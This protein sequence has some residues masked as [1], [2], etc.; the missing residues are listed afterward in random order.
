MT[1]R[2]LPWLVLALLSLAGA[3]QAAT[4][5]I[6][7]GDDPNA[8]LELRRTLLPSGVEVELVVLTG[9]RITLTIDDV[10]I[11]GQRIELDVEGRIVRVIGPGSFASGSERL[12]GSDMELRIDDEQV[13]AIDAVVFTSAIDV[14]GDVAERVPGQVSFSGGL[15]SPCTR[16]DQEVLD[17]AFRA[18]R[19][20]LYPGD[21]LV[22][23][24]V[25]LLLR[26]VAVLRLPLL[27]IPL[28]Q[29]DRQPRLA[30]ATGSAVR[31]AEVSLRWPY[32]AGRDALG[33][34]TVRY[35]ADV[36]P[37]TDAGL[38]G[39]LLG[40]TVEVS[41]LGF[42][43]DHRVYDEVGAGGLFVAYEPHRVGRAA[44]PGV[45]ARAPIDARWTVRLGYATAEDGAGTAVRA[46]LVRDDA[47]TAGR[48]IYLFG[49]AATDPTSLGDVGVR[50]QVD[51]QGF[52]DTDA[53]V[54]PRTPPAYADRRTPVR[55]PLRLRFE[56]L[57]VAPLQLGQLRVTALAL[58]LGLFQD[59]ANPINRRAAAAGLVAAGRALVGHGLV[60]DPWSP[61]A[62]V[63]IEGDNRFEGRYYG[64]DERAV[65]WRTRFGVTQNLGTWATVV[66]TL[67]RD[68]VEGETPFRF[69]AVAVR[70]RTDLQFRV[71][72]RPAPWVGLESSGGYVLVDNR[73]P[74]TVGWAPLTTRLTLFGDRP[75]IDASLEHVW[76]IRDDDP[77]T[78][79]S[80]LTLQARRTPV[81]LLVTLEHLQDLRPDPATPLVA[82]TVTRLT[83]RAAYE[84]VASLDVVAAYRPAPAPDAAGR[85]RRFEPIDVRLALGSLRGGDERPGVRLQAL[86]DPE[87]NRVERLTVD[88]RARAGAVEVEATQ[89]IEL[90]EGRVSDASL[91]VAWD[92]VAR[93]EARGLVWLPPA[94]LG[95]PEEPR[96]RQLSVQLR[97]Q[98][99]LGAPRWEA[100]WRSTVDPTLEAPGRRDTRFE[101]RAALLQEVY[102]PWLVSV[103]AQAEW[104]LRDALQPEGFLRRLSLVVGADAWERIGVQGRLG[105]LATYDRFTGT[106]VRRELTIDDLTLAVRPTDALTV[107]ARLSDVW[108]LTGRDAGRSPWTIRPEVFFV[109]DRCCWALSGAWNAAT[110]TVRIVLTGPG[111]STGLEQVLETG[112]SLP[113]ATLRATP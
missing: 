7:A 88:L 3:A 34:F 95:H 77:G 21:R 23:H 40:G 108:E 111:T 60:L 32:V 71:S 22:G 14:T 29:G 41:Y 90:P 102:G 73:R 42:E 28:A 110:G 92:D 65:A 13:R 25:T 9:R 35:L 37:T 6:D 19:M 96:L 8:R 57:D 79:R 112:W 50:L 54:G 38:L 39:R 63:R 89:R 106:L 67:T 104:A 76:P 109:W 113:R 48:W 80:S 84:R 52:V 53:A 33:T 27:V 4:L 16:C 17:Y 36:D 43:L 10:V 82:D 101:V 70:A 18:E 93:L 87:L 47:R 75:W 100:T 56:P 72:L 1:A 26:G 55:T 83:W 59:Y 46:E 78:L 66:A 58:D 49:L 24:D 74:E 31:R 68:V 86:F 107:G 15:A 45:P 11:V 51:S 94:W 103:E 69:D 105:Y 30:I 85:L 2:W 64:S 61:W 81:E 97:E 91:V 44:T 62:G 5:T 98:R 99:A 12:E 20:V